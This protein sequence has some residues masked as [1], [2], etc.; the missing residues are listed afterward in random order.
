MTETN[1]TT[2]APTQSRFDA[3]L[4]DYLRERD[5]LDGLPVETTSSEDE[6]RAMEVA[7]AAERRLFKQPVQN[8]GDVRSLAEIAWRD[9]DS[10]PDVSMIGAVINGLRQLDG[11]APSRTFRAENWL[12]HYERL[13]GGWTS[14]EGEVSLLAPVPVSEGLKAMLWEL[15]TRG[16]REQVK[17]IIRDTK[18]FAAP[19]MD[20]PARLQWDH[21]RRR[22]EVEAARMEQNEATPYRGTIDDPECEKAEDLTAQIVEAYDSVAEEL[23]RFP[24]P[25][26][27]ALAFKLELMA[28]NHFG[29][30]NNRHAPEFAQALAADAARLLKEA[31]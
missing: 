16:G 6:D 30:F 10:I 26:A 2:P 4:A 29:A 22:F 19:A 24:A 8:V 18:P 21:M 31:A 23:L 15:D 12:T 28:S 14:V 7:I 17:A 25:D 9:P 13:G 5:R 20:N 11:N 1:T 3:A 27:E